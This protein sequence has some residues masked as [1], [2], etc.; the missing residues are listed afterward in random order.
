M[1]SGHERDKNI[2]Q[3][4]LHYQNMKIQTY[5]SPIFSKIWPCLTIFVQ[6]QFS[7]GS[8]AVLYQLSTGKLYSGFCNDNGTAVVCSIFSI[9]LKCS[10]R[11][12]VTYAINEIKSSRRQSLNIDEIAPSGQNINLSTLIHH[13]RPKVVSHLLLLSEKRERNGGSGCFTFQHFPTQKIRRVTYYLIPEVIP[14]KT[15]FLM[16]QI[17]PKIFLIPQTLI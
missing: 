13:F 15:W 16:H 5:L 3:Y 7:Y 17:P 2:P 12:N 4:I 14:K 8:N 6:G 9:Y 11:I 10:L 1:Y